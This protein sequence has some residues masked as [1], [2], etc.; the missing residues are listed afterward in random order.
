MA[1]FQKKTTNTSSTAPLYTIGGQS[2]MLIV[3]LGNP[4]KEYIKTRHNA[5]FI[6]VDAFV[7]AH[8]ELSEW[9]IKKD[10]FCQIS[11]GI[12]GATRVIVIKPTTFMNESGRAVQAV[13]SFYKIPPIQ[14][15]VLHDELDINFGQIRTRNGGG[16]AG[17]NGIKSIISHCGDDF[18]RI[19]IGI[20][21]QHKPTHDTSD[22]VLKPFND[23]EQSH[24]AALTREI[25]SILI[26]IIYRGNV[27]P[28][29]RSFII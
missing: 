19:R 20:N 7:K 28:E 12:M 23:T 16:A 4:G 27:Q 5:G 18:G 24:I 9:V 13:Q 6:S 29:T 3:G 1:L 21:N 17:H 2:T 26:E 25:E 15:V 11:T 22:F 14:T 10:L 8:D